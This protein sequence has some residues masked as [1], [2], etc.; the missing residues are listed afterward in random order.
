MH[1]SHTLTFDF[2]CVWVSIISVMLYVLLLQQVVCMLIIVNRLFWYAVIRL[3]C[4]SSLKTAENLEVVKGIPADKL[5]IETGLC[6]Y[7][8]C[9][10]A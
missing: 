2:I 7:L 10:F 9:F 5:L 6:H 8:S 4:C 3:F 1:C